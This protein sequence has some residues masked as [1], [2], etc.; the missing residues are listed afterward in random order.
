[1][2]IARTHKRVSKL[3]E[4]LAQFNQILTFSPIVCERAT[5]FRNPSSI[6]LRFQ[7]F[8]SSRLTQNPETLR[9]SR[10]ARTEAQEALFDYLHCT[11]NFSFMDA[12]HISKNSPTFVQNLLS[13][14]DAEED[15]TRSLSRFFRYHPIN[16]FEPFFESIGLNPSELP[17]LL[18]RH[19]MFLSDDPV[20]LENFHVLCSYGIP[21]SKIGTMYREAK[22]IFGYDYGVMFSKLQA[23][24]NLGLSRQTVV[25]LVSCCPLLLV[26]G[27]NTEFVEVL[28]KLIGLGI[29]N[30]WIGGYIT[31]KNAYN[32]K[33]MIEMINFLEKVGYSREQMCS[34]FKANP[35][36]LLEGSG[37]RVYTL[38]G[39]LLKLGIGMDGVSLMFKQNPRMLSRKCSRNLLHAVDFMFEIGMPIEDTAE[40]AETHMDFLASVTLKGPKTVCK[41][42]K[43]RR[44]GLRQII[45]E[46]PLKVLSLASKSKVKSNEQASIPNP[47]K[48]LEKASFLSRLGYVENTEEMKDAL[49]KFRG[50]GDQLQ[51][52][53]DCLVQAGLDYHVAM[54]IIKLA[55]MILNQSKDVIE[56]KIDCLTNS[57]G[58]P[59]ESLIAFP[60]Y[61]CYNTDRINIRFSMYMWLRER[62]AAK[63]KLKLSTL[64]VISDARF[65][66]HFVDAHPDGPARW[67]SLKNSST[68]S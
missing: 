23:Y 9:V 22:E 51:E 25:K 18:P 11:R 15:I 12:E 28:Q 1:M 34:L 8:C 46:D 52:R 57:V 59:L 36:A 37:K 7:C 44:Q 27:V 5:F 61:L 48:H 4:M 6:S 3:S 17:S 2:L 65:V 50:R 24:E 13:E 21:R 39:R 68:S 20:M 42:L 26:G 53:F 63:P 43:V 58:Y 10:I 47:G 62:G 38:F 35:S 56:K 64:L 55:P 67:E 33:R 49:K 29:N 19:L 60:A 66:K 41:E 31:G 32:W 45:K 16:E 30:D 40:I 54:V 14:V